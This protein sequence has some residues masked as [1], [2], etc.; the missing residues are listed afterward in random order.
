MKPDIK[1]LAVW[2]A[3]LCTGLSAQNIQSVTVRSLS[4]DDV[5]LSKM[6]SRGPT[7]VSFWA[8]WCEP[9]KLEL[10]QLQSMYEKYKD[11]NFSILAV[12]QDNQRSISKVSSYIAAHGYTY[13]IATDPDNEVA[14]MFNVQNIPFSILYDTNG[15]AVYKTIGYKPGDE[16]TLEEHLQKLLM[17][18]DAD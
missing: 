4:G 7:L 1:F 13:S 14:Q 6:V 9:C 2:I 3:V 12:N 18:K 15:N 16:H 11:R 10:R 8:L 5:E 17:K